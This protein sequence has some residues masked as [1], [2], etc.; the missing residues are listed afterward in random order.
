M[1]QAVE[2]LRSNVYDPSKE[3]E[4]LKDSSWEDLD[5]LKRMVVDEE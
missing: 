4:E 5:A 3:Q 1:N 2:M